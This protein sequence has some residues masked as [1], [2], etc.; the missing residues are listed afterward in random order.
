MVALTHAPNQD[1]ILI[2]NAFQRLGYRVSYFDYLRENQSDL[3]EVARQLKPDIV[4]V[5]KGQ[6]LERKTLLRVKENT[7]KLVMWYPDAYLPD[8]PGY[9]HEFLAE[10]LP[11]FDTALINY[12]GLVSPLTRYNRE[13]HF[14]PAFFD[15]HFFK[16]DTL[17]GEDHGFFGCDAVFIGNN[18]KVYGRER[19]SALKAVARVCHLKVW[20]LGWGVRLPRSLVAIAKTG[21]PATPDTRSLRFGLWQRLMKARPPLRATAFSKAVIGKELVDNSVSKAYQCSKI[22]LNVGT[23]HL[24]IG[25]IDLGFSD[26]LYECM[27]SGTAYLTPPIVNIDELFVPSRDLIVYSSVQELVETVEYLLEDETERMK[28]AKNGYEKIMRSHTIDVRIQQ[29]LDIIYA[30]KCPFDCRHNARQTKAGD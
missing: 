26:R 30:K 19:V 13:C 21:L 8:D 22:G 3:V 10:I 17:T 14:A 24:R 18:Q 9:G 23:L 25:H 11:E 6:G 27:G 4:F 29:Y 5:T 12:R 28:I 1:G 16:T 20:G 7:T 2:G 15:N